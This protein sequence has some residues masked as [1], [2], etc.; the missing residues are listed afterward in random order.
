MEPNSTPKGFTI[1]RN[2]HYVLHAGNDLDDGHRAGIVNQVF[3]ATTGRAGLH[4][5]LQ[6]TDWSTNPIAIK[7][8]IAVYSERKEVGTW[9]YPE[10]VP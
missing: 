4:V 6:E 8:V 10:Y 9:H 2:V 7:R 1:C 5:F 3:E